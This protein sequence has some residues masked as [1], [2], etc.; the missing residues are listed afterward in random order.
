MGSVVVSV[1]ALR[2]GITSAVHLVTLE[3]SGGQRLQAVRR[4]V[5]P[6]LNAEEPDLPAREARACAMS[7]NK[8]GS[9]P[10]A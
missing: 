5:R 4:Y 8:S 7:N 6:E 10:R 9:R 2:G 1:Q 3:R